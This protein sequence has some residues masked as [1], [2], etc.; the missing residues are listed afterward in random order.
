MEIAN[1]TLGNAKPV[2][3]CTSYLVQ[4][5]IVSS[6]MP[7]LNPKQFGNVMSANEI[8]AN[9][10]MAQGKDLQKTAEVAY[11]KGL[12]GEIKKNWIKDPLTIWHQNGK[13]RL[14]D[15]HHRLSVALL[16]D[17]DRPIPVRHQERDQIVWGNDSYPL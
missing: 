8:M 5:E 1:E 10:E 14:A 6:V 12:G 11:S 2:E 4:P 9:V 7:N 13:A 3:R 17:P 15:G 16:E